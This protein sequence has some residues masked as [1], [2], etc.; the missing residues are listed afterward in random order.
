MKCSSFSYLRNPCRYK[1]SSPNG[2]CEKHSQMESDAG[3]RING[4]CIYIKKNHQR[5]NKDAFLEG[6]DKDYC[7]DHSLLSFEFK[8]ESKGCNC[9]KYLNLELTPE[10]N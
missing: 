5:C 2:L 1:S 9:C 8:L 6:E 3:P 7:N 4:K 10:K